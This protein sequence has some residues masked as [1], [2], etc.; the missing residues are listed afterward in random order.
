MKQI[1]SME[2]NRDRKRNQQIN[3][4][5]RLVLLLLYCYNNVIASVDLKYGRR[6]ITDNQKLK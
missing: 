6:E 4:T 1:N 5:H 3:H 2:A